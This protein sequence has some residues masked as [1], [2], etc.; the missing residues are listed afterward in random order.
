MECSV[1]ES[2][3]QFYRQYL[4]GINS[5]QEYI[6]LWALQILYCAFLSSVL[7]L[8]ELDLFLVISRLG[9]IDSQTSVTK[10]A[11]NSAI[12][13]NLSVMIVPGGIAEMQEIGK[14]VTSNLT[15][16]FQAMRIQKL[17]ISKIEEAL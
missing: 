16:F 14:K 13:N 1:L 8:E 2:L 10:A 4:A 15:H 3:Q 6:Q 17:F 5:S 11:M 9:K 7:Y 12:Q